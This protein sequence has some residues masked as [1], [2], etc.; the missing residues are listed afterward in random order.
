[1]QPKLTKWLRDL[2]S[3]CDLILEHTAGRSLTDYEADRFLQS[4]IERNFEII[5]EILM[6]VSRASPETASRITDFRDIIGFR[7]ILAHGYDVVDHA[8]VWQV[9]Q[10]NLSVLRS[11]AGALL[12]ELDRDEPSPDLLDEQQ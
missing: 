2:I 6:R 9:I 8:R 3:A 1:M 10:D 12:A 5:G 4:G 11:E 7:N